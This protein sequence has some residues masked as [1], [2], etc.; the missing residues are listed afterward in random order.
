MAL[1]YVFNVIE[2]A[3]NVFV[4][5]ALRTQMK[6]REDI[7][8]VWG[9]LG[10]EEYSKVRNPLQQLVDNAIAV[11]NDLRHMQLKVTFDNLG[12]EVHSSCGQDG[13]SK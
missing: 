6:I 5:H 12:I 7:D 4:V 13:G 11:L 9:M 2:I 10:L 3:P 8:T 1:V